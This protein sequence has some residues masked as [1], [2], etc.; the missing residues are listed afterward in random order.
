MAEHHFGANPDELGRAGNEIY[1]AGNL[2]HKVRTDLRAQRANLGV[3]YE[4]GEEI[5]DQLEK[6]LTPMLDNLDELLGSLVTAFN[7]TADE[8]LKTRRTFLNSE[9]ANLDIT[10]GL[11]N[12]F[13]TD[14]GGTPGGGGGPRRG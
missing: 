4:G 10:E 2:V 9:D 11:N 6:N 14:P 8:T 12:N 3:I 5:G 1:D 13:D 7:D